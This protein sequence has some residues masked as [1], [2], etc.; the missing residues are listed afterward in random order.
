M[1]I[2]PSAFEL[3]VLVLGPRYMVN[4]DHEFL[5]CSNKRLCRQ[6]AVVR[7]AG[8]AVLECIGSDTAGDVFLAVDANEANAISIK[9]W[10]VVRE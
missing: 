9:M 10:G 3:S 6:Q 4:I 7:Q 1:R 8:I 2:G 5:K